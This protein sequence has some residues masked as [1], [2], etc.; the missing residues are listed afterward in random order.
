MCHIMADTIFISAALCGVL[1]ICY[2]ASELEQFS[3]LLNCSATDRK[4]APA[5][6]TRE[7]NVRQHGTLLL[8]IVAGVPL[9]V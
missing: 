1:N 4:D 8:Q 2:S 3:G 9:A 7:Q 5:L 6:S